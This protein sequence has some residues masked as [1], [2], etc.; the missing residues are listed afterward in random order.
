MIPDL[1]LRTTYGVDYRAL[2]Q[3]LQAVVWKAVVNVTDRLVAS[4]CSMSVR[5][6]CPS[7]AFVTFCIVALTVGVV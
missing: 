1:L 4:Y 3:G 7:A 5:P 2:L 6:S